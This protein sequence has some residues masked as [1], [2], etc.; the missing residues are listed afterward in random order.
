M[1]I[2]LSSISITGG[3]LQRAAFR[4][5]L[6]RAAAIAAVVV[7]SRAG[8]AEVAAPPSGWRASSLNEGTNRGSLESL[9]A[10]GVITL[11]GS[12]ADFWGAADSGYFLNKPITGDFRIAVRIVAGPTATSE[13]AKAGLMIR[14]SLDPGARNIHLDITP[15]HGIEWQWRATARGA[16]ENLGAVPAEQLKL[17][18]LLRLTRQGNIL[19]AECSMDEGKS[20][21]PVGVPATFAPP[22][23]RTLAAGLAVTAHDESKIT[24]AKFS[25]LR[26]EK[27]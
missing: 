5:R 21:Q 10:S 4:R 12:G 14:D 18:V 7:A 9:K 3:A 23:P 24:E 6:V 25:E 1:R 17:P 19:S 20:F 16:T 27:R 2:R 22:L 15:V 8:I 13:W 11:R 26:I